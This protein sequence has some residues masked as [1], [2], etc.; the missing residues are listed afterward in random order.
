MDG[1][2]TQGAQG[3]C[4]AGWHIPTD[5]EQCTLESHLATG[6]CNCSRD[7]GYD[8]DPAGTAL[9]AGGSSG[10]EA[11]L[12]GYVHKIGAVG[13]ERGTTMRYWSSTPDSC[14]WG[15]MLYAAYST[16]YRQKDTPP[17]YGWSIR[18]IKD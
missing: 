8:C 3:L 7:G 4:P 6:S 1:S 13:T 11:L 18:C 17:S 9:K 2:T 10:F 16:V 12:V 15:R 5:A 14:P